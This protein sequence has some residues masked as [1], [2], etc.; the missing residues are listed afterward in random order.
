MMWEDTPVASTLSR[1]QDYDIQAVVFRTGSNRPVSG[2]YFDVM[3]NNVGEL[4]SIAELI[5]PDQN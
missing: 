3:S 2:D 5:K 1:L 4:D